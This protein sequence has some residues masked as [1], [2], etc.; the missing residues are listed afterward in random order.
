V[1][2]VQSSP[3]TRNA[4]NVD[5]CALVASAALRGGGYTV[6]ESWPPT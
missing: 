1:A 3:A 4:W 6:L 5:A 2:A